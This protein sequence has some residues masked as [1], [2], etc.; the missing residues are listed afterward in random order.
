MFCK[1]YKSRKPCLCLNNISYFK[2]LQSMLNC[3]IYL[4]IR[5]PTVI[6]EKKP[7]IIYW[8]MIGGDEEDTYK[9]L[10]DVYN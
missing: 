5:N 4:Y 10:L 2:H 8:S 3:T 7:N 6:F 1:V 9:I